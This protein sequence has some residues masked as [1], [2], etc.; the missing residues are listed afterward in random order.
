MEEE[1]SVDKNYVGGGLT[2]L[3]EVNAL[4]NEA[5]RL[6]VGSKGG[7]AYPKEARVAL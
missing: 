2:S 3:K 1:E 4:E 7:N 5:C 6:R